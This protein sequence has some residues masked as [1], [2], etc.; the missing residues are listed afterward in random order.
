MALPFRHP[1]RDGYDLCGAPLAAAAFSAGAAQNRFLPAFLVRSISGP[2][3]SVALGRH[4]GRL[5][6]R[7][8]ETVDRFVSRSSIPDRSLELGSP[9][10][11][12]ADRQGATRSVPRAAQLLRQIDG[13]PQQQGGPSQCSRRKHGDDDARRL[14]G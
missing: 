2:P 11:I 5:I 12:P 3:R 8:G 10:G 4:D 7:R 9:S 14:F 13:G 6:A 1:S